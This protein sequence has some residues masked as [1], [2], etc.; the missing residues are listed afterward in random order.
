MGN[1][2]HK[3]PNVIVKENIILY[4]LLYYIFTVTQQNL[5]YLFIY[6]TSLS[7]NG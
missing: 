2:D 7:I 5:E 1:Y 6:S 4:W 3:S